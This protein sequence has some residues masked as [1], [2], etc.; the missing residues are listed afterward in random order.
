M[1]NQRVTAEQRRAVIARA[2]QCCEY[3]YSQVRFATESF[4]VEHITPRIKAGETELDNLA[5]SCQ[6]CNNFKYTKTEGL[7][8]ATEQVVSLFNPR[9]QSWQ[10]HFAWNDDYTLIIGLTPTGRATVRE[11]KLNRDGLLNL[12]RVLFAMGEHPPLDSLP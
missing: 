8:P 7:D 9:R 2:K 1:S 4:S 6:G 3:C 12:R 11:L 10:D 5:L